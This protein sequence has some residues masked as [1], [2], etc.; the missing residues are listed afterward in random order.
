MKKIILVFGSFLVIFF[1][2]TTPKKKSV[3]ELNTDVTNKFVLNGTL[4]NNASD[5][6][7]LNKID[8]N[9][10]Y[11]VDSTTITNNQF[12][13]EGI[14]EY[15]ERFALTFNN[16]ATPVIFI[17][18]NINFQIELEPTQL[19]DPTILNSPLNYKLNEYKTHSKNIF[20]KI[21][22]LFPQFQKA[23]LENDADELAEIGKKMQL[24]E[25]EFSDFS[26]QFIENNAN[27]YVSGMILRDQLKS[28]TADTVKIMNA[29]K[30]LST[31]VKNAPDATLVA[32]TLK[33]H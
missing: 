14:V 13:F 20:K 32:K 15:P 18:E 21:D 19:Q 8:E 4:K 5:K 7:Y 12:N 26:F 22:Y 6:V 30:M 10:L 29:Y 3:K 33:L 9:T 17:L 23:R 28:S 11:P 1:S 25:E 16:Y 2:C 31:K 27:S 24:I